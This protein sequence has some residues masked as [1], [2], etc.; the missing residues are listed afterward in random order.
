M[1]VHIS[2]TTVK[3]LRPPSNGNRIYYD[4]E[5]DGFGARVTEGGAVSFI[6]NYYI[7]GRERRYTIGR[8][9]EWSADAAR[10]EAVELRAAIRKG[11]DPLQQKA[12]SRSEPQVSDLAA[13]YIEKHALPHKRPTSVRND[14]QMLD[15]LIL[16]SLGKLRVTAVGRRDIEAL[17]RSLKATPYRA[18]RVLALLSSM[19]SKAVEWKWRL[20]NPVRGIPRFHEDEREQWLSAEQLRLLSD[21]LDA[22]PQQ[23]AANAIRLL[24]LT[25]AREG[26]VLNAEWSQ[27][28]LKRGVWTKP[29]HHVKQKRIEHVPL[30]RAALGVLSGM[31]QKAS[32]PFLFPGTKGDG[33]RVTIRRPWVQVLKAAGMVEEVRAPA[34]RREERVVPKPLVRIHDLRHTFASHLVSAGESLHVVGKLLGHTEPATT[35]RYAH[36]ADGAL[37]EAAN[38]FPN[39]LAAGNHAVAQPT[40][41]RAGAR[42]P[43]ER[44]A[45]SPVGR[46]HEPRK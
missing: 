42:T 27:F 10:A 11:A 26:E 32:S 36:V 9:P 8:W 22:Y 39:L 24:A 20:D 46:H 21:A 15:R 40:P 19:F 7:H 37:R 12:L 35:A 44:P 2:Q 41:R 34:K 29:S 16:P 5:I 13:E 1:S 38:R 30:N 4:D 14:R 33:P 23:E 25:G 31:A 43:A 17:H 18:N 28:D 3:K 6:L 45:K